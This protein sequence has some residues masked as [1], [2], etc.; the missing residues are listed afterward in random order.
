MSGFLSDNVAGVHPQIMHSLLTENSGYQRPYGNDEQSAKLDSAFS[1]LFDTEVVVLPCTTGTAANALALSLMAGPINSICV[2]EKSHVYVDECNAPEFFC[3]GARLTPLPGPDGKIGVTGLAG[4]TG[5]IGDVHA[6]QPA[7]ISVTQTTEVGSVYAIAEIEEI[8][9]FARRYDIKIHMDGARFAN[10][11]AALG[12]HPADL[13]WRAGVDALSF[14]ATKNGCMAAEAV[15]LFDKSL[16]ETARHRQKRAGQL[17]SKQRFL[18][19][20]LLAYL[21]DDL[22]LHNASHANHKLSQLAAMLEQIEGVTMPGQIAS[23]MMFAKFTEP[24]NA[25]L[26]K[27]GLAGYLFD[28]GEMRVCCSWATTDDDIKQFAKCVR[29]DQR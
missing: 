1:D 8:A 22:W 27:A 15:V 7:A 2:H 20:Q 29:D 5:V 24:Q 11:V 10:A 21:Q 28:S 25:R 4:V 18:A 6:P 17:L 9:H 23:N 16:I 12:C 3:G 13:T 14:G 26:Q 19:T